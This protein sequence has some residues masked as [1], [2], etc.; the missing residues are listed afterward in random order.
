MNASATE[1]RV[2]TSN[3][4][5][6]EPATKDSGRD[7]DND[8]VMADGNEGNS[9]Q[10]EA[11]QGE[12]TITIKRKYKFAGDIITEEKVVPKD[13]AEAKLY[14]SLNKSAS[15]DNETQSPDQQ[16]EDRPAIINLR[17]PLRRISRFD[18]NPPGA[19]K[20]SWEKQA[21]IAA[22]GEGAGDGSSASGKGPKL[23]TVEKSK[24]DWAAYVDRAGIKD[25]LDVHSKA[26]EGY[27]GRMEFLNRI[28][29]KREEER[30]NARLKNMG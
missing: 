7:H 4:T 10:D 29:D 14:L 15:T 9:K 12:E 13:S 8:V 1:S 28:E 6:N 27:H 16:Q 21:A 24:L 5:A 11:R 17:R 3:N 20:R 2:S 26:K 22:I 30:R 23:N 18:P 19:I 25:D